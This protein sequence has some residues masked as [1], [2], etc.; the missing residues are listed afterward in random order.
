[1]RTYELV[2]I[3]KSSL[4]EEKRKKLLESLKKMLGSL[5]VA[6]EEVLGEKALTYPI[7]KEKSGYYYILSLEGETIPLDFEKKLTVQE[8]ILRHLVIRKK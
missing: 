5:K 7:K 2:L 3:L 6:N 4:P 8:D 1:M